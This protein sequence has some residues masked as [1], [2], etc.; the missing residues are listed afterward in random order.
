MVDWVHHPDECVH[1]VHLFTKLGTLLLTKS[2]GFPAPYVAH[3][4]RVP[5]WLQKTGDRDYLYR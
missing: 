5:G 2:R 3:T 4:P 1:P